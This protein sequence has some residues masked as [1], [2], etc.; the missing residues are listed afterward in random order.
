MDDGGLQRARLWLTARGSPL[1][2]V[3]TADRMSQAQSGG[4]RCAQA[5]AAKPQRQVLRAEERPPED[6]SSQRR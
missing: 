1:S 6:A 5:R 3:E 2:E 4:S